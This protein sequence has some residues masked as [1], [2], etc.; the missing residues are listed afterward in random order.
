MRNSGHAF[1]RKCFRA[2]VLA[3]VLPQHRSFFREI[4]EVMN[5]SFK[6]CLGHF[7]GHVRLREKL[8]NK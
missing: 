7:A 5:K 4:R 3:P 1:V 6:P 2:M 8:G